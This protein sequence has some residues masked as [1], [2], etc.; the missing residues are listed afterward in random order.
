M[1]CKLPTCFFYGHVISQSH[2]EFSSKFWHNIKKYENSNF[3]V[4]FM[5][6]VRGLQQL[7]W[8]QIEMLSGVT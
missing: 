8:W 7:N 1:V 3:G 6:L 5:F 4:H 2:S